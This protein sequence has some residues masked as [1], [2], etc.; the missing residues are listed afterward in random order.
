MNIEYPLA[1]ELTFTGNISFNEF[2]GGI[3]YRGRSGKHNFTGYLEGGI[4]YY[5]Y[6]LFTTD[7]SNANINFDSRNVGTM[8]YTLG[9]EFALLPKIFLTLEA[10]I[11]HTLESKDYWLDNRWSYG[12][13]LGISVPL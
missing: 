5:G 8:R 12:V 13:T 3:G 2:I 9:Y 10:L 4:R 7:G 1:T 6:P 11:S